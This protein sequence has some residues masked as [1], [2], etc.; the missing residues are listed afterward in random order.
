M[1]QQPTP[2]IEGYLIKKRGNHHKSKYFG[3]DCMRWFKLQEVNGSDQ[4][5]LAFC[6][7]KSRKDLEPKGWIFVKDVYEISEEEHSFTLVSPGRTMVISALSPE[8]LN[9]WLRAMVESCPHADTT[10]VRCEFTS[11]LQL[12]AAYDLRP[13]SC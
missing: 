4:S 12:A 3:T 11:S 8:D 5:E 7:F 1:S 13:G 9:K 2:K 10:K 6:Y